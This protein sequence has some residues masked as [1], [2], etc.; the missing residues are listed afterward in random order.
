MGKTLDLSTSRI[1]EAIVHDNKALARLN[2]GDEMLAHLRIL[3]LP[4]L[5]LSPGALF[6][7][8]ERSHKSRQIKHLRD[9][10]ILYILSPTSDEMILLF[11]E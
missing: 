11:R 7:H 1:H 6:V 3:G 5:D 2:F 8:G 9:Q 4:K 10:R